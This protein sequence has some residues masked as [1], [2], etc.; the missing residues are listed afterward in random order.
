MSDCSVKT[1]TAF[2]IR[3]ISGGYE[4]RY[5]DGST[6]RVDSS[7]VVRRSPNMVEVKQC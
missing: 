6:E 4:V 1:K 5:A 3:T 2:I 7:R